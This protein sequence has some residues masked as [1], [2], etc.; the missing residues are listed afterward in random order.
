VKRIGIFEENERMKP[1]PCRTGM[2]TGGNNKADRASPPGWQRTGF[3]NPRPRARAGH[4]EQ[5]EAAVAAGGRKCGCLYFPV[6]SDVEAVIAAAQAPAGADAPT[7][8]ACISL[9]IPK[10]R[11]LAPRG[12][13]SRPRGPG[14]QP[15]FPC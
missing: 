7:Y 6:N 3:Q 13:A 11:S 5:Q 15:V 12:Q 2:P 1:G 14:A 10:I 8:D 9:L 4:V